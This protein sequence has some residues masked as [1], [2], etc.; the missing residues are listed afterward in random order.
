MKNKKKIEYT[1]SSQY[2]M[3][4]RECNVE[5]INTSNSQETSYILALRRKSSISNALVVQYVFWESNGIDYLWEDFPQINTAYPI[6]LFTKSEGM[7]LD[8]MVLYCLDRV[9]AVTNS[10]LQSKR[11]SYIEYYI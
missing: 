9:I 4:T 1:K 6:A 11:Q 5:L 7:T 8:D 3:V 10:Y 2:K